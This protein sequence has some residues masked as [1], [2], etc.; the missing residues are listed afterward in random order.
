MNVDNSR[1]IKLEDNTV[2]LYER[3]ERARVF[4]ESIQNWAGEIRKRVD[5]L[6]QDIDGNSAAASP[7][8]RRLFTLSLQTIANILKGALEGATSSATQA[9]E[10][11]GSSDTLLHYLRSLQLDKASQRM[12]RLAQ[13]VGYDLHSGTDKNIEELSQ[14]FPGAEA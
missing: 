4:A 14:T 13:E 9:K 3:V 8:P 5:N 10:A 7:F 2:S 6:L 1:S 11:S 12:E